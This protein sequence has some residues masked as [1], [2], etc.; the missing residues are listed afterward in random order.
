MAWS[1]A[2]IPLLVAQAGAAPAEKPAA[3]AVKA[4]APAAPAGKAEAPASE[5]PTVKADP[6]G[7][8]PV[9]VPAGD[10]AAKKP[11][12]APAAPDNGLGMIVYIGPLF[13]LFYMLIIRP[14]RKQESKQKDLLKSLKKNDKVQTASGIF[15]T[16]VSADP[17]SDKVVVRIDDDKGV[18]V[19]FSKASIVRVIEPQ[20]EKAAESSSSSS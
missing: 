11:A 3:P 20:P 14:Q 6:A 8:V 10:A 7:P 12:A 2:L 1:L 4:E 17:T 9:P 5:G 18:K 19:T 16:V 13:L 15:G